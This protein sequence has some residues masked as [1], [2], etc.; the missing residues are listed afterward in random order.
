MKEKDNV[1]GK[2][3]FFLI[4]PLLLPVYLNG[5]LVF[6][7]LCPL[8]DGVGCGENLF[9]S[10]ARLSWDQA[11]QSWYNENKNFKYGKGATYPG[12]VILHYTQVAQ[13]HFM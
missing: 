8:L 11:I 2:E 1:S 4:R 6:L 13:H 9:M 10:T 7:N 5:L 3:T 12:A